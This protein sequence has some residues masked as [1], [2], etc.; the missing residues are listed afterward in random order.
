MSKIV[1]P[2]HSAD[3]DEMNAVLKIHYE[4][5]DWVKGPDFK[6]KLMGLIGAEQ[7]PSSY[8]K[9]AQVPAYFG[10]LESKVSSGGRI[11]ERKITDT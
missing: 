10:F 6:R 8:P 11:T 5:D 2:K 3:I 1:I 4:A 7:Y 9:K